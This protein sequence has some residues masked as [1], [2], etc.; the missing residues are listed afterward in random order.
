MGRGRDKRKPSFR[1]LSSLCRRHPS[2]NQWTRY[3]FSFSL[4]RQR[5]SRWSGCASAEPSVFGSKEH[6]QRSILAKTGLSTKETRPTRERAGNCRLRHFRLRG[7]WS[8]CFALS[9]A[10][11]DSVLFFLSTCA[12]GRSGCWVDAMCLK[13]TCASLLGLGKLPGTAP[14]SSLFR[15]SDRTSLP[16]PPL[17]ANVRVSLLHPSLSSIISSLPFI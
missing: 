14:V 9:A 6:R 16:P 15:D 10:D 4:L 5:R 11:P 1:A 17:P 3:S 8:V 2:Y 13:G 12:A 7:A